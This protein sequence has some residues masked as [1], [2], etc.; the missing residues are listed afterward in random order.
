MF[1]FFS[2]F[3]PF[4]FFFFKKK[5]FACLFCGINRPRRPE[6]YPSPHK[7]TLA[8]HH[9]KARKRTCPWGPERR[10][11]RKKKKVFALFFKKKKKKKKKKRF[12]TNQKCDDARKHACGGPCQGSLIPPP[13]FC[14]LF[15]FMVI[16]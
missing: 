10:G 16:G 4:L 15:P 9:K 7:N 3:K 11:E 12:I 8:P 2:F 14:V 1:L 13:R 6:N 5:T